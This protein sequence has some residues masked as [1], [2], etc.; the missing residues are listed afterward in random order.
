VREDSWDSLWD[1]HVTRVC[2]FLAFLRLG[3]LEIPLSRFAVPPAL[4][5]SRLLI[6]ACMTE[7]TARS[8]TGLEVTQAVNPRELN[9]PDDEQLHLL[10]E[11]ELGALIR[12]P[13]RQRR[14]ASRSRSRERTDSSPRSSQSV[15]SENTLPDSSGSPDSLGSLARAAASRRDNPGAQPAVPEPELASYLSDSL[16]RSF[17]CP[18][19]LETLAETQGHEWGV[20]LR[21]SLRS[22]SERWS[23]ATQLSQRWEAGFIMGSRPL[24]WE[25]G[26][27]Q[28]GT[29]EVGIRADDR[30]A[31]ST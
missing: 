10:T 9:I 28:S 30:L 14:G 19:Q 4:F 2:A 24:G 3:L 26:F 5:H 12:E 25:V 6:R 22:T 21:D 23:A 8:S 16:D 29:W 31:P 11:E 1:P 7:S 18:P 15:S 20:S 17:P 27:N 13:Y